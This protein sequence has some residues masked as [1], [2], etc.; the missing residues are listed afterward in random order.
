MVLVVRVD[1]QGRIVIPKE[2]RERKKLEGE[3]EVVEVEEGVLVRSHRREWDRF[4]ANKVGVNWQ[5]ALAVSLENVSIDDF[6]FG[7]G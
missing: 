6:L 2:V 3:V 5:K 7:V 1:R 4:F